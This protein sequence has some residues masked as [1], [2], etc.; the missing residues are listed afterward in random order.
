[1]GTQLEILVTVG[2]LKDR[3]FSVPANGIRLG[4]SSS[5]EI[6]IPDPALSRNHCLFETR[7][8]GLWVTDLASANGTLVNDVQLGPDSHCLQL[9]DVVLV[10]DSALQVVAAEGKIPDRAPAPT[11]EPA[12][13]V[14]DLG[15]GSES[16]SEGAPDAIRPEGGS[17]SSW[18]RC[19]LWGVAILSVL[20]AAALILFPVSPDADVPIREL[21]D[22]DPG[23]LLSFT[24]E[25]VKAGT[26]AIYRYALVF[27]GTNLCVEVDDVSTAN[28][29]SFVR[30]PS[31]DIPNQ[32][33]ADARKRLSEIFSSSTNLYS[34]SSEYP[35][36]PSVPGTL[37]SL[38]LHVVRSR[39]VLDVS[40]E[41]AVGPEA[42]QNV[43]AKLEAFVESEFDLYAI[44][45]P[46]AR[47][48]EKSEEKRREAD[49][50]WA[51]R[52][53]KFGNLAEALRK[54]N[55]A[56]NYLK[57]V[58]PKP[59]DY[60]ALLARRKDAKAELDRVYNEH[61][62]NAQQAHG[63]QNR[64]Q[65]KYELQVLLELVP[66]RNDERNK[67]AFRKLR[68]VENEKQMKTRR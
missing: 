59:A 49:A 24:Y 19:A 48:R 55:E 50:K 12:L 6:S 10:G 4:R 31:E 5:C 45:I 25:R 43:C 17:K 61:Y 16:S 2:P 51:E 65:E 60:E 22:T 20:G 37:T 21:S 40:V 54:Y 26:N 46:V 1:M 63:T 36:T 8:G 30:V 53:L 27:D 18:M 15:L 68:E 7:D 42:L 62:G 3:R 52:G 57:T 66:D 35:G 13:P 9:G 44:N 32:L 47:R 23:E 41:N 14:I 28:D 58:N 39:R 34:L 38:A 33:S 11:A 64:K 29:T 67:E 56:I